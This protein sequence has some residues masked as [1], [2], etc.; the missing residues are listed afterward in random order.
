MNKK[1]WL[2]PIFVIFAVLNFCGRKAAMPEVAEAV[3]EEPIQMI[4]L[5]TYW[6][7]H[8]EES[9]VEDIRNA[10]AIAVVVDGVSSVIEKQYYITPCEECKQAIAQCIINR[11]KTAGFPNTII[12]VC[13]QPYQ[14]EG[15]TRDTEGSNE[16][17]AIAKQLLKGEAAAPIPEDCVFFCLTGRG[18]EFRNAWD[19]SVATITF[20]GY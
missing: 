16:T 3:A 13:E 18:I 5:V 11:A 12:E 7:E 10:R 1:M 15:V 8:P 4:D 17:S 2:I 20:I 6:E 19:S 9:P 14:W